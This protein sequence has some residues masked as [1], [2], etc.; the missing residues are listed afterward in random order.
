M[1]IKA[2]GAVQQYHVLGAPKS[3]FEGWRAPPRRTQIN[4]NNTIRFPSPAFAEGSPETE[5]VAR[6]D[7]PKGLRRRVRRGQAL[8]GVGDSMAA[9]YVVHAGAVKTVTVSGDRLSQVTGFHLSGEVFGLD[10]IASGRHPGMAIALEDSE[11]FVLPLAKCLEWARGTEQGLRLLTRALACELER[12]RDVILMLGTMRAEQRLAAFLLDLSERYGRLGFSR[13]QFELRM[14]RQDIGS[15]LGLKIETVSRLVSRLQ[16]KG[17]LRALNKSIT[18]V[19][20]DGL[21]QMSGLTH[22][23]CRPACVQI[24]DRE[25]A[26]RFD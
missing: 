7:A 26:L 22:R 12:C 25:G 13:S 1:R 14:S 9:L 20:F 10:G 17:I 6:H 16:R 23:D 18:V 19:D 3:G 24:V 21:W 8:Y 2:Y 11:V 5:I 4:D 15:Y